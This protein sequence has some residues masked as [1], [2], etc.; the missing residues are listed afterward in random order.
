V[1]SHPDGHCSARKGN[2]L[3]SKKGRKKKN[4]ERA[5]ITEGNYEEREKEKSEDSQAPKPFVIARGCRRRERGEKKGRHS[6]V[7][8]KKMEKEKDKGGC[9]MFERFR[10]T[11]GEEREVPPGRRKSQCPHAADG[12]L[13]EL[14]G[15]KRSA[16]SSIRF[17]RRFASRGRRAIT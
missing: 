8:R 14:G 12:G 3:V 7:K 1:G 16:S 9:E 4:H 5:G 10:L 13:R 17:V 6:S 2:I 11:R 15:G